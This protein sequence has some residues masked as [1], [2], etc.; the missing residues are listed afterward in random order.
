MATD[1][2]TILWPEVERALGNIASVICAEGSDYG[3]DDALEFQ[4]PDGRKSEYHIQ[5]GPYGYSLNRSHYDKDGNLEAMTLLED[6]PIELAWEKK[7]QQKFF[8]VLKK[9]LLEEVSAV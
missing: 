3:E 7:R 8:K 1:N 6:E 9:K 5:C 4:F 2:A